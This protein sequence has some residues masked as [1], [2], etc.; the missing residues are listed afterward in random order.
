MSDCPCTR[1]VHTVDNDY[2]DTK[3]AV[4]RH[5]VSLANGYAKIMFM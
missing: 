1:T 5:C 2:V 4:H 3:S